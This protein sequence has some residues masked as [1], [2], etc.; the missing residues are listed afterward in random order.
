MRDALPSPPPNEH[1]SAIVNLD[2]SFGS[3][4]HWVCY[5][6]VKDKVYYFDSFG[7]LKPPREM[8]RY[9]GNCDIYYNYKRRQSFDSVVCGHLCLQF[10]N[11]A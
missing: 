9:F 8:L 6:K 11:D 10:L 4:T 3:G 1:E 2:S 7:N 5:K